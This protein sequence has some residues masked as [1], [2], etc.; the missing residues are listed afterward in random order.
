[1]PIAEL[2]VDDESGFVQKGGEC[3]RAEKPQRTVLRLGP[4]PPLPREGLREADYVALHIL[5]FVFDSCH[6]AAGIAYL[7]RRVP[8][9]P[10]ARSRIA[11][12]EREA[13]AVDERGADRG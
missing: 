8:A 13:A 5:D 6:L 4:V 7:E 9:F 10:R 2:S 12:L 3:F 11:G 1:M